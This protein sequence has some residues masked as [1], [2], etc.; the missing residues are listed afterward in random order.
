MEKKCYVY[1]EG[2]LV[3]AKDG[4][5]FNPFHSHLCDAF[6]RFR[7]ANM[8]SEKG[9]ENKVFFSLREKDSLAFAYFWFSQQNTVSP[10]PVH[11]GGALGNISG[12]LST[13]FFFFFGRNIRFM[14][15]SL[16][17]M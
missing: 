13:F 14:A 16:T 8:V 9:L 1:Q 4:N 12:W 11:V 15:T 2:L 3:L 6:M 10:A 17:C 7:V 5:Q